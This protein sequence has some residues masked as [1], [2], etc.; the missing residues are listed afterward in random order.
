VSK[1]WGKIAGGL[2]VVNTYDKT[3]L[4]LKRSAFVDNPGV[5]GLPGGRVE[6]GESILD[7]VIREAKEELGRYPVECLRVGPL[8]HVFRDGD[9]QYHTFLACTVFRFLGFKLNWENSRWAWFDPQKIR[10]QTVSHLGEKVTVDQR[11][12]NMLVEIS[13]RPTTRMCPECQREKP[14]LSELRGAM[15]RKLHGDRPWMKN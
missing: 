9:F 8:L 14:S 11:V 10:K 2:L 13:K 5:W 3:I 1:Y 4:L 7:G 12:K 15:L 6:E